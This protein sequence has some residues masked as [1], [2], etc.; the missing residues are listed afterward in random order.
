M[1]LFSLL[2]AIFTD[3]GAYFA[4]SY[5][6]QFFGHFCFSIEQIQGLASHFIEEKM[7]EQVDERLRSSMLPIRTTDQAVLIEG[8]C[9]L[10]LLQQYQRLAEFHKQNPHQLLRRFAP[11][12]AILTIDS[13]EAHD[14]GVIIYF[15]DELSVVTLALVR[16]KVQSTTLMKH[17]R[18]PPKQAQEVQQACTHLPNVSDTD[19]IAQTLAHPLI[20]ELVSH[21]ITMAEQEMMHRIHWPNEIN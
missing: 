20:T 1:R 8:K 5:Q 18:F 7:R 16:S 15:S 6:K 14:H 3:N 17:F 4:V 10:L 19:P 9:A 21:Q 2:G 12:R 11:R 13:S